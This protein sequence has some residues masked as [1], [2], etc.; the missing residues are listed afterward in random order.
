M[1][2]MMVMMMSVMVVRGDADNEGSHDKRDGGDGNGGELEKS[3]T[4]VCDEVEDHQDKEK[5]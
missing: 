4:E 2:M 3:R 5:C 1:M